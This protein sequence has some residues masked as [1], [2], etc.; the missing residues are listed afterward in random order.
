[1]TM[2]GRSME[3][4]AGSTEPQ[5]MHPLTTVARTPGASHRARS[6]TL[7]GGLPPPSISGLR[8]VGRRSYHNYLGNSSTPVHLS[9]GR[10]PSTSANGL[11]T[12]RTLSVNARE[13]ATSTESSSPLLDEDYPD[14]QSWLKPAKSHHSPEQKVYSYEQLKVCSNVKLKGVDS[15]HREDYLSSEDFERLFKMPRTAFQRL[16]E[17]KKSDLKRRLDL[18]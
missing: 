10:P 8:P 13:N 5:E 7:T 6:T 11:R 3:G 16:P 1:M 14:V 4:I 17:W 2:P 15:R 12:A 18:Y 9:R